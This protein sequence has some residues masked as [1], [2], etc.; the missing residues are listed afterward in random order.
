VFRTAS[1]RK[2][3]PQLGRIPKISRSISSNRAGPGRRPDTQPQ[4][5]SRR[6]DTQQ[7]PQRSARPAA[8]SKKPTVAGRRTPAAERPSISQLSTARGC[9][10]PLPQVSLSGAPCRKIYRDDSH[11]RQQSRRRLPS[12]AATNCCQLHS[13]RN[14]SAWG[15][16][17]PVGDVIRNAVRLAADTLCRHQSYGADGLDC[18]AVASLCMAKVALA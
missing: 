7:D 4:P 16:Y 1:G 15:A 10:E 11:G 2:S 5:S 9:G 6:R 17:C 12:D 14:G 8:I 18:R 13:Y 3:F